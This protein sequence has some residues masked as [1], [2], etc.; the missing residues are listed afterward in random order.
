MGN[1]DMRKTSRPLPGKGVEV[2][3]K[4]KSIAVVGASNRKG[5]IGYAITWNLINSYSGKIYPINPK[6]KEILG[7]DAY[8]SLLDL[9]EAPDLVV[10]TVKAELVPPIAEEAGKKGAKGIIVVAGGFSEAGEEGKELEEDLVKI[11]RKYDMRLIGPNCIGVYDADT[12]V[13][14]FFIPHNRMRRPPKGNIA[15][16]SQSGAFLTTFM[17]YIATEGVGIIKAVNFGNKADVDEVD[18]LAY[19]AH[20]PNVDTIMMYLE[21]VK[22]GRG[23]ELINIALEAKLKYGKKIVAL[24]GGKS[25]S[26]KRAASSHTAALAGD[27][28]VLS[29]AFRQ[30]GIVEVATPLEFLDAAKALSK[31]TPARGSKTLVLTHAGGP[32]VIT[33][34]LLEANGLRVPRL[35][36]AL[37]KRLESVF[38]RRVA[39]TN[40]ID[41]TGDA[42]EEDYMK[43]L[44]V[45]ADN[46]EFDIYIVI[47][48][49]QPPTITNNVGNVIIDFSKKTGKP[50]IVVTGA[51]PEGDQ[52]LRYLDENN[53]PSYN[54]PER[55]VHAARALTIA[56]QRICM[57][58]LSLIEHDNTKSCTKQKVSEVEAL[59][60][61]EEVGIKTPRYCFVESVSKVREC[62]NRLSKP[63]V[64]KLVAKNLVHKSDIG[65]V[66][67]G[68]ESVEEAVESYNKL[69]NLGVE[70][71]F[72]GVLFQEHVEG[73]IEVFVGGKKDPVFGPVILFGAGGTLVEVYND[74]SIRVAPLNRCE[75]EKMID[76]TKVS[77]V[78]RGYRG[79]RADI[80]SL[81]DLVYRVSE[82]LNRKNILELDLNP[83]IVNRDGAYAVDV[84]IVRCN[85]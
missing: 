39:K 10:I 77:K 38:P 25:E 74:V 73:G 69:K 71:G 16:I 24:K 55:A 54:L 15:V 61:A 5:S 29:S 67:L 47:A 50:V 80:D 34:D 7:L 76:E 84:R 17:D 9:S 78:L 44:E 26:G 65:G 79:F 19:L 2:F 60:L 33:T 36:K 23:R 18:L 66:V 40:P 46:D 11:V 12:G 6:Y 56:G 42:S 48:Y 3:F 72:Q 28:R 64:A 43:A 75:A 27:Y 58:K 1:S 30:A 49:I 83:I 85:G 62:Y 59:R 21:D 31:S 57:D 14:T 22:P 82:L 68:I 53:I 70:Y 45:L 13:D 4:P 20:Q 52:L 32:G 37:V 63:L 41:L 81:I 8:S 35:S 51:S